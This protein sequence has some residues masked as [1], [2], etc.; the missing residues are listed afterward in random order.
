MYF[1]Y[2]E[3]KFRLKKSGIENITYLVESHGRNDHLGMPLQ[4]LCQ[5]A[6]NTAIQENFFIKYTENIRETVEYL[7]NFSRSLIGMFKVV[8]I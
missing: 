3:Q 5:A 1:R 2:H 7:A 8:N 6:T 4:T